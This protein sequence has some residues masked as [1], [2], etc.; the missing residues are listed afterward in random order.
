MKDIW[1]RRIRKFCTM[2][3]T[4]L[5]H[6]DTE[7]KVK[8]ITIIKTLGIKSD[9]YTYC[10]TPAECTENFFE[11]SILSNIR[12]DCS[13]YLIAKIWHNWCKCTYNQN[14]SIACHLILFLDHRCSLRKQ[15]DVSSHI[16]RMNLWLLTAFITESLPNGS[17]LGRVRVDS[18]QYR[19]YYNSIIIIDVQDGVVFVSF[20]FCVYCIKFIRI[21]SLWP[22]LSIGYAVLVFGRWH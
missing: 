22:W 16:T 4:K 12:G 9:V 20:F 7:L 18:Q 19:V 17:S 3:Y 8:S 10:M 2:L 11:N 6:L 13:G 14:T 21:L 5:I 1:H 15:N